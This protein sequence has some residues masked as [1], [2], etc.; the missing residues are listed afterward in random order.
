MIVCVCHAVSDHEIR[1]SA[2]LG[3]ESFEELQQGLGVGTCCG[4]CCD[5]ARQVLAEQLKRRES[6]EG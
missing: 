2:E 1:A 6:A 3:V 5:C 4:Q